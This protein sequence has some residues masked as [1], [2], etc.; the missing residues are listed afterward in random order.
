MFSHTDMKG[1]GGTADVSG[2]AIGALQQVNTVANEAQ[3]AGRHSAVGEHTLLD[4]STLEGIPEL[5]GTVVNAD[6]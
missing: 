4:L 2:Q 5:A 6:R 3:P 1:P